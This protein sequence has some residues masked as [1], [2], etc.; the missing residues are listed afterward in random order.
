MRARLK[1]MWG[2]MGKK[3]LSVL[4]GVVAISLT[5]LYSNCGNSGESVATP[6]SRAGGSGEQD[7]AFVSREV[8][9][10]PSALMD[11]S[12]KWPASTLGTMYLYRINEKND[13]QTLTRTAYVYRPRNLAPKSPVLFF[14][15]GGTGSA[16]EV[17]D[18]IPNLMQLADERSRTSGISWRKNTATCR[19]TAQ[20][21]FKNTSGQNCSPPMLNFSNSTQF[22]LVMPEGILSKNSTT[23]RHWEDGRVP[24]PGFDT[25]AENRNDIGFINFLLKTVK[26]KEADVVHAGRVYVAGA[27]NGGMMTQKLACLSKNYPELSKVAAFSSLVAALPEPLISGQSGRALCPEQ[28][29]VFPISF[30]VGF[31]ISQPTCSPFGCTTPTVSGD[32]RMP[33]GVAGGVYTVNSPDG[34]QVVSAQDSQEFF[35]SYLLNSGAGS[36]TAVNT[37]VGYYTNLRV[38]SFAGSA[39][40]IHVYE[41]DG[42]RHAALS[43]RMDFN[44]LGRMWSFLS[45]FER[46]ADNSI[47]PIGASAVSGDY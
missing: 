41:T 19:Y 37:D 23:D 3:K 2:R 44:V 25:T 16:F 5:L 18:K 30:F 17:I 43:T 42:G 20:G 31:G 14:L 13:L 22:T 6:E 4:V 1:W 34:G 45:S 10:C 40:K 46:G 26:E 32:G 11:C 21:Q 35:V 12:T 47:L 8:A 9:Q 27:S 39:I 29:G 38:H 36:T 7:F 28:G 33:Y 15:H 24:S